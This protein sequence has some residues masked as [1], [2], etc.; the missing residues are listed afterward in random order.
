MEHSK[1][2][3]ASYDVQKNK[4][5]I[6]EKTFTLEELSSMQPKDR[7]IGVRLSVIK[8]S[9]EGEPDRM[10]IWAIFEE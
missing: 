3:L 4:Y 5:P 10:S 9:P 7:L 1:R 6:G 8:G 2:V